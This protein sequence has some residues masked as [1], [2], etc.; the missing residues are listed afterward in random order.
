MIGMADVSKSTVFTM[1]HPRFVSFHDA[2]PAPSAGR[3]LRDLE[4]PKELSPPAVATTL[5]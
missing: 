4:P 2:C 1:F 3:S 5:W